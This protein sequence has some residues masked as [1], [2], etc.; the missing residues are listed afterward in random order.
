MLKLKKKNRFLP[1]NYGSRFRPAAPVVSCFFFFIL[2]VVA[3][4]SLPA[5]A[6]LQLF[7]W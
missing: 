2:F 3:A 6:L 4:F 5:N 1:V 7:D